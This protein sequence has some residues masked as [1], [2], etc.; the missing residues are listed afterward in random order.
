MTYDRLW[1]WI[2]ENYDFK[3]YLGPDELAYDVRQRF[4]K[5][6][7]YFPDKLNDVIVQRFQYR[8]AYVA[9]Q[10][11][12]DEQRQIAEYLGS[13]EP[14]KSISDEIVD[15]LRKPEILDVNIEDLIYTKPE[16]Y[17]TAPKDLRRFADQ[18]AS[19]GRFGR[20]ISRFKR[21]LRR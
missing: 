17:N 4:E 7:H 1:S 9:K 15:D 3:N 10:E 21:L 18:Q 2:V 16:P 11:M 20:I 14:Y 12:E 19:Q 5:D 6:G 13:G 8:D